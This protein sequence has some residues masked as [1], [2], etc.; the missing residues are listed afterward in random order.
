[1]IITGTNIGE[2]LQG[3]D[4]ND[5]IYGLGGNDAI[6]SSPGADYLDGG[7]DW[8]VVVYLPSN[9]GVVISLLSGNGYRGHAAGD[10]LV[11]I[12]EL[13]GSFH[14]DRLSGDHNA[15][16]LIGYWGDDI[17]IGHGGDDLL[18]GGDGADYLDGG[19]GNDIAFYTQSDAGVVVS[20]LS[21]NGYRGEAAGDKLI[22]IEHLIGS[23]YDDRL[24]GDHDTNLIYGNYGNDIIKGRQGDDILADFHGNNRIYG[25]DGDDQ[26]YASIDKVDLDETTLDALDILGVD[27]NA[28]N[29]VNHLY[30]GSGNDL[31]YGGNNYNFIYGQHGNDRLVGGSGIDEFVF[32]S[33][34]GYDVVVDFQ[35]DYDHIN[36]EHFNLTFFNDLDISQ[37]PDGALIDLRA[38][39]SGTILLEGIDAAILDP[40]DF[41]L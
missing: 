20:L 27:Y 35:D 34:D 18:M 6:F 12:E 33:N 22:N 16:G 9:T 5:Q 1:M 8:D 11:N 10:K 40:G 28:Y 13:H 41:I 19:S 29:G 26:I 30:G 38:E 7:S 25:D 2:P 37:T 31:I 23:S 21:G 3:T 14:N 39:G 24:F 17:L 36:L 15:N 32:D 4:Q